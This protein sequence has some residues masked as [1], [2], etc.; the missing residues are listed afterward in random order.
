MKI[1]RWLK[2]GVEYGRDLAGSGLQGARSARDTI[3]EGE[4]VSAV[5]TRSMRESWAPTVIGAGAGAAVGYLLDR[6]KPSA[7]KI[8][9][10]SIIGAVLGFGTG[11]AWETRDLSSG[12]A[13]GARKKINE[14]RDSHWLAKNPIDFG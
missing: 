13:R 11:L 6:R 2:S 8:A 1:G 5:L 4:P 7:G 3:L 10:C 12:M 9:A 14:T